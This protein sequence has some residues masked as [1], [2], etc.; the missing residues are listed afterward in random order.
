M[1]VLSIPGPYHRFLI[2]RKKTIY[3]QLTCLYEDFTKQD[4]Q[5]L[6]KGFSN[7]TEKG[8]LIGVTL[9]PS[10]IRSEL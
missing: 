9:E 2:N 3:Y 10:R 1:I 8:K 4:S 5:K 6:K 7:S